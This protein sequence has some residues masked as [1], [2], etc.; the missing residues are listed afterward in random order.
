MEAHEKYL[1]NDG[2]NQGELFLFQGK[3]CEALHN[4]VVPIVNVQSNLC[5][6]DIFF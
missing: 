4:A 5:P 6:A 1:F 3:L 2:K